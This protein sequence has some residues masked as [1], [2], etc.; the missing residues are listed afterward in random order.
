MEVVKEVKTVLVDY[1][2]PN[3]EIGFMRPGGICFPV[4]PPI[5]QHVCNNCGHM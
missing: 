1:S 5:Y 4:N 3:C 2:C